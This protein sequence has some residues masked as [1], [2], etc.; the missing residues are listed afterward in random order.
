LGALAIL[1]GEFVESI[2]HIIDGFKEV[3]LNSRKNQALYESFERLAG[4]TEDLK[5][6]TGIA[7]VTNV[8]FSQVFFYSLIAIV[9]FL[10]PRYV[11]S[12]SSVVIQLTAAILFIMAPLEMVVGSIPMIARS[13][14]SL[15]RLYSLEKRLDDHL[16][17]ADNGNVDHERFRGF[18]QAALE[19]TSFTYRDQGDGPGFTVGPVDVAIERGKTLFIVGGNG[20]GKSTLLK[21]LTGLYPVSSGTLRVDQSVLTMPDLPSYRDLISAIFTDFHLF[22]RLYGMEDVDER[23]VHQLIAEMGLTG[24]TDF[25]N[26]RFTNLNL[27]T[28]QRKRLAL[29][30]AMLED[31]EIYVFDEWAADQDVHFREHFYRDILPALRDSGKAVVAVTH[32]DR[33]WEMADR[34]VKLEAGVIVSV[35]DKQQPPGQAGE[36]P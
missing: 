33:Y 30:I 18:H 3:R 16:S 27:S 22:D 15:D 28:G 36:E 7:L 31:R 9:V 32:D 21:M 20:S 5:T 2:N 4:R 14:V 11:G 29:I 23:R 12:V 8:M 24:K 34:L 17:A 19:R 25:Q 6:R 35:V 26:G 10:L 1:E 13:S